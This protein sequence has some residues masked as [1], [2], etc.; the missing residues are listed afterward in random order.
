M[1]SVYFFPKFVKGKL[2]NVIKQLSSVKVPRTGS[3]LRLTA[4]VKG[5]RKVVGFDLYFAL[6]TF[7]LCKASSLRLLCQSITSSNLGAEHYSC[8]A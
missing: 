3:L 5:F 8:L 6:K 4:E 1:L 2:S 7:D